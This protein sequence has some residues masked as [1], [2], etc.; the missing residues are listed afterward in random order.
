MYIQ[1]ASHQKKIYII[2]FAPSLLQYLIYRDG[3][4]LHLQI[5]RVETLHIFTHQ[6]FPTVAWPRAIKR[7]IMERQN[8]A[9]LAESEWHTWAHETISSA[10][11]LHQNKQWEQSGHLGYVC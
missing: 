6:T 1:I 2:I 10:E 4:D 5:S 7:S 9:D 3:L 8:K 11:R